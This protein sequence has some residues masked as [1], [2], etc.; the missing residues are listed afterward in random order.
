[1]TQRKPQGSSWE[2]WIERQIQDG[3]ERGVFDELEGHGEPLTEVS[4]VH[5]EM[6]WVKAKLRDEDIEYLP[7]TI[8]IKADRARAIEAAMADPSAASA[9]DKIEAINERIRDVNRYSAA[10]PPSSVVVIDV[11]VFMQRWRNMHP[12]PPP[13]TPP[14]STPATVAPPS[15]WKRFLNRLIRGGRVAKPTAG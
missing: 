8:A 15:R 4:G 7:P 1:M 2:S 6:W 13:A 5:D 14:V 12:T 10:G 9:L 11:E 3:H